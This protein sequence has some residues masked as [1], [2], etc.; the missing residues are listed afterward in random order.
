M[1]RKK[2]IIAANWKMHKTR[3]EVEDFFDILAPC[4][5]GSSAQVW[6]APPSTTLH[7]A[8]QQAGQSGIWVG[9]Q[10]IFYEPQGAF[11]G[12]ISAAQVADAGARFVIIGHSE[13]RRLFAET[14]IQIRK[15]I[16]LA[17]E[18][19]LI[20]LLCIGETIQERESGQ[21][22]AVLKKQLVEVLTSQFEG[23]IAYEPV[24]AIGTGKTADAAV[25]EEA[26]TFCREVLRQ[27]CAKGSQTPILYGGSVTAEVSPLL[28]S[29]KNVDGALVGGASLDALVFASIIQG[30]VK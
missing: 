7:L 17:T 13:R 21:T 8:S 6:I 26:H 28:R 19:Q 20:P 2:P 4:L 14:H 29:I 23:V 18:H 30:Y 24:W 27:V 5:K 16:Q 1:S 10:N 11:T 12:E 22:Q 15:K 3:C 25:I 9:A